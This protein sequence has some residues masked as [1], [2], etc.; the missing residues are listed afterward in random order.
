MYAAEIRAAPSLAQKR[1]CGLKNRLYSTREY[2][3]DGNV[4]LIIFLFVISQL[5]LRTI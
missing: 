5:A 3:T 4:G 2:Q 1:L